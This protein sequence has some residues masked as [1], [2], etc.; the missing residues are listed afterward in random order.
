MAV[1]IRRFDPVRDLETLI[2]FMPE[3]YESNFSGFRADADFLTRRR[4]A[5]RE[6]ARD[7]GQLVLVADDGRGAVG[8][9]WLVLEL[10]GNGRRRGEVAAVF[11]APRLRGTG[12]GRLLMAEAEAMFRSWGCHSIHLMVTASNERALQLY[13]G[14]G[15]AVTR[16]QMEKRLR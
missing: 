5:L 2:A 7:P 13:R 3:L 10:D 9:V 15:F 8:F 6:A 4:Q 16:H 1:T 12:I 14:L 11:V